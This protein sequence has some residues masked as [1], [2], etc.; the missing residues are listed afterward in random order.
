[1]TR[2]V[3]GYWIARSSRAMTADFISGASFFLS[4]TLR[5]LPMADDRID[6]HPA[7][8]SGNVAVITGA[9]SGIGLAAAK[10]YARAGMRV[11]LADLPGDKLDA[12]RND[13]AAIAAAK[14]GAAMAV[15]VDV[16][17]IDDLQK[18]QA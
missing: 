10:R 11:C 1:M 8:A 13:V 3:S 4:R 18:L 14:G 7:F 12:A 17:R 16:S 15:G 6:A 2:G 5:R 9:A